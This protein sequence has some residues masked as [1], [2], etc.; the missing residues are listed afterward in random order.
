MVDTKRASSSLFRRVH[1]RSA[2]SNDSRSLR[3]SARCTASAPAKASRVAAAAEMSTWRR[4]ATALTA[5]AA[6]ARTS[7]HDS[8]GESR[9][10]L[11]S[12]SNAAVGASPS[13]A[14]GRAPSHSARRRVH[15]E[16]TKACRASTSSAALASSCAESRLVAS[17]KRLHPPNRKCP[18]IELRLGTC[19]AFARIRQCSPGIVQRPPLIAQRVPI[20]LALGRQLLGGGSPRIRS[21]EST[22]GSAVQQREG[23]PHH[24]HEPLWRWGPHHVPIGNGR[25]GDCAAAVHSL[26]RRCMIARVATAQGGN[27]G[28]TCC[29]RC[30]Y[31]S[32]VT[33]RIVKLGTQLTNRHLVSAQSPRKLRNNDIPISEQSRRMSQ[34]AFE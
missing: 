23:I 13:A 5:S 16:R 4:R 11:P 15:R 28:S 33:P 34:V 21:G 2:A 7:G 9:S 30:V 12:L 19:Q 22:I 27:L 24:R 14:S 18:F 1:V 6:A 31:S 32:L 8:R 20:G 10:K 29:V 17:K 25:V 26:Q 3:H